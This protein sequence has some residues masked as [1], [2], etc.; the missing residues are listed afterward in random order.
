MLSDQRY[1]F[2]EGCSAALQD[3]YFSFF[4]FSTVF[5]FEAVHIF[6]VCVYA[7]QCYR[8]LGKGT[9]EMIPKRI[10]VKC[11]DTL[12]NMVCHLTVIGF[13]V[14][15]LASTSYSI[16]IIRSDNLCYEGYMKNKCTIYIF[17]R[18]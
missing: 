17:K 4:W 8:I 11:Q 14:T 15:N 2:R 9:Q 7:F 1:Y 3:T 6:T 18:E 10:Y 13:C 5:Q 12:I 16:S